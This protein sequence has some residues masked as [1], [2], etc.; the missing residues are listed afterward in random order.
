[1]NKKVKKK[2][3]TK[4][5]QKMVLTMAVLVLLFLILGILTLAALIGKTIEEQLKA[6]QGSFGTQAVEH[7]SEKDE[8]QEH[9][10]EDSTISGNEEL[11]DEEKVRER[12]RSFAQEHHL[13]LRDYPEPLIEC[14]VGNPEKEAFVLNYPLKKSTYSNKNLDA[15]LGQS[16]V[17]LFLQWDSRWG[18]YVYGSSVMGVTGCGPTCLSMVALHLLQ[19]SQLP[20]PSAVQVGSVPG[21]VAQL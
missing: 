4:W 11:S 13:S 21:I 18:Y 17:P 19:A 2:N 1:M 10:H 20:L 7:L 14:L 6:T 9:E 3:K 8:V 15:Y 5:L 16:Q 12:I